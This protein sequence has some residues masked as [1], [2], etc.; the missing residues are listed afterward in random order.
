MTKLYGTFK[1]SNGYVIFLKVEYILCYT[2]K[3]RRIKESIL[4]S[5]SAKLFRPFAHI[6]SVH[7]GK[8]CDLGLFTFCLDGKTTEF[9]YGI[10]LKKGQC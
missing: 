7:V 2:Q 5:W 9:V 1:F 3:C 4:D 8:H 6:H 10:T